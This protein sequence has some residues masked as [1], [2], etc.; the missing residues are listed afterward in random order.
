MNNPLNK[1]ISD[2]LILYPEQFY[3]NQ[4]SGTFEMPLHQH[5]YL[6]LN[7]VAEG[8]CLYQVANKRYMLKKRGMILLNSNLP[9]RLIFDSSVSCTLM[10][11]SLDSDQVRMGTVPLRELIHHNNDLRDFSEVFDGVAVIH[12][13]HSLQ[14]TL[15]EMLSECQDERDFILLNLLSNKL[16]IGAARLALNNNSY[17]ME[18]IS[19]IKE[20]IQFNYSKITCI[21]DIAAHVGLN[22]NYMQRIFKE[23]M[24]CTVWQFLTKVRMKQAAQLL[25][26][27]DSNISD[28]DEQVGINSRQNFYLLFRKEFGVSPQ[29]YRKKRP[30]TRI[31]ER[32]NLVRPAV[33]NGGEK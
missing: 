31:S 6:E 24:G 25:V 23:Q 27:T 12:D 28:L 30:G 13:A 29:Q 1:N 18:H 5:G 3:I 16:L 7:Y 2:S 10:G 22:K 15:K 8:C 26:T 14:H 20:Y 11:V 33:K 4:D 9:H 21:D 19:K 32:T 17:L